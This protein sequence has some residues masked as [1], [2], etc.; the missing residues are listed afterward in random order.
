M[1]ILTWEISSNIENSLIDFLRNEVTSTSLQVLD[2]NGVAKNVNVYAGRELNNNWHLP[3]I[4]IYLDSKPDAN[5]LEIG[6]NKRL[7]SFQIIID[8][9][10]LLAGQEANIAD[11]VEEKINDGFTVYDYTPNSLNVNVPA[12]VILG[13]GRVDFI[14]SMPVLG[15]DDADLFDKNRYRISIKVWLN[16]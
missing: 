11:W 13:H 8:I 12:K 2:Q 6:T 5:R 16:G 15:Y 4:Q 14:T 7:R 9:R 10:T 1:A 3:L